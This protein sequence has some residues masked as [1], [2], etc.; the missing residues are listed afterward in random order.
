MIEV[1]SKPPWG[2]YA[3]KVISGKVHY[4]W[5]NLTWNLQCTFGWFQSAAEMDACLTRLK[6]KERQDEE[7]KRQA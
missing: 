6:E 5:K 3:Y 1:V 2:I 4:L 7:Q